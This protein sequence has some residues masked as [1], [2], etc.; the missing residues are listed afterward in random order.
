[1]HLSSKHRSSPVWFASFVSAFLLSIAWCGARTNDLNVALLATASAPS[2]MFQW[3]PFLAPFHSVL[4]H[5][6][7]GFVTMALILEV[8]SLFRPSAE[9]RKISRLVMWLSLGTAAVVAALG[10]MR[11]SSGDY[12]S[13]TLSLHRALGMAVPVC[14]VL[15]LVAQQSAIRAD[16]RRLLL[17]YRGLL[18]VTF[19]V[20]IGAGH[21]GGNLTHG[22]KYLIQN[23]PGFVKT[24]LEETETAKPNV[25]KSSNSGEGLFATK[26]R[27]ILEAKCLQ[28][29]GPKKHK[30][31]YR[32]DLPEPALKGGESGL[33]AI[34]PGD[35]LK[36]N[37]VRLILLPRDSD[38]VM[39]PE[40]KEPLTSD[41]TMVLIRWIQAGAPFGEA[42]APTS[43]EPTGG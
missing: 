27:P 10:I 16:S 38:E 11:A 36:S 14:I 42:N 25:E 37:L 40:G 30:G 41:E 34:K 43:D 35:P 13:H 1:M 17:A 32:L 39:P 6:P 22:S 23:A 8:Y 29:H 19:G 18:A 33:A 4:L 24:L 7:I 20:L 26:V 2:K 21:Q 15:T 28:C 3:R 5:Y 12:D 9:L 31:G